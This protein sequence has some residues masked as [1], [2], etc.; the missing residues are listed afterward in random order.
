[1]SILGILRLERYTDAM[2]PPATS[3]IEHCS[4]FSL[5]VYSERKINETDLYFFEDK[6]TKN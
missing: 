4:K 2:W 3:A 6:M 1:M 5:Y